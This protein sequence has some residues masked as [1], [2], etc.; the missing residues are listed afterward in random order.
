MDWTHVGATILTSFMASL[1]EFVEALT[2][3][4]AVGTIRGWRSA[5]MGCSWWICLKMAR[6][7]L[8]R[9]VNFKLWDSSAKSDMG[10]LKNNHNNQLDSLAVFVLNFFTT[11]CGL[12]AG[13]QYLHGRA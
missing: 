4:L 2:V 13:S 11:Y 3:V 9:K 12:G 7:I 1:V 5:L 6:W 8:R 10:A